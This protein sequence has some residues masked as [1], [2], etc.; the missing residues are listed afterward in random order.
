MQIIIDEGVQIV[1]TSAGNPKTWT[2]ILKNK[3]I[4]VVH[5]SKQQRICKKSGR[6]GL[7]TQ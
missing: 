3:G 6:C 1:F 2:G 7:W 4:K 5:C